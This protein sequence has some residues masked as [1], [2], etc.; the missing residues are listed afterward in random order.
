MKQLRTE[1]LRIKQTK[2]QASALHALCSSLGTTRSAYVRNLVDGAIE[3][4]SKR[5][6]RQAEVPRYVENVPT[7]F[8]GQHANYRVS[9]GARPRMR[10]T[11]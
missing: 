7:F 4:N 10:I 3:T 1:L 9:Y 2:R 11:V 5:L 8:P 6:R